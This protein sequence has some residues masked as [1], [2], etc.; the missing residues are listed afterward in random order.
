L[1][2]SLIEAQ[3]FTVRRVSVP[4]L[5]PGADP[6]RV[7]HLSDLHLLPR[8]GRKIGWLRDLEALEPDLVV[9]TG[10]NMAHREALPAVLAASEPLLQLPG[11]SVMASN[12]SFSPRAS[13]PAAYLVPDPC[14][15]G[16]Q[17]QAEART[18]D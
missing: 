6:V 11:V 13:S 1:A 2:W 9:N 15:R 14:R 8:Q 16:D 5:P 18:V 7:L 10:D 3:A 12:A 4:V 17:E